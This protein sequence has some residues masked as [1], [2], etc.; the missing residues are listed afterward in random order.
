MR[1][2]LVML[3]VACVAAAGCSSS[4]S[5]PSSS[6]GA[7]SQPAPS[8]IQAPAAEP[9]TAEHAQTRE[10]RAPV[11]L[12]TAENENELVAVSLPAGRVL[13]RVHLA[14]DPTTVTA[15]PGGPVVVVS[16]GSGTVTVL[17]FPR[18]RPLAVLRGFRS[19]Q[20]AAATPDGEWALVTDAAAGTVS[21]VE[22]ANRKVVDRVH[23]G[24]GAHHI[25]VSPDQRTAWVAL[26]ET[27]STIVVL[28]C[29][30]PRHL[31]V[32]RRLRPAVA[33]HDLAFSPSGRAVWVSS[34]SAPYVSVLDAR[35][36]RLLATVPAGR[37]PQ[38]VAFIR[39]H[40]Y[41]T[42]GYG[43]SIEMVDARSRRVLARAALPYGSFNLASFGGMVVT[44][45]LLDGRVTELRAADLRRVMTTAV[46]SN[47]RSVAVTAR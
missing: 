42:S 30:N 14:A 43:S 17:S 40:V 10:P 21:T 15:G 11:A 44:T 32:V 23:V 37:A 1:S 31:R 9:A 2:A 27:A 28:D 38:H 34:S 39:S 18:L 22:F 4:S 5:P 19:P 41:I 35:S 24:L 8:T 13:R 36:G 26:G 7:A 46:A 16:P 33:A 47:A 3:A 20:L 45:S 12:V 6:R 29:T 25:A